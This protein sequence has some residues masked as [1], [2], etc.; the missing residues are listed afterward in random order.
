MALFLLF[1]AP[2]IHQLSPAWVAT[3]PAPPTWT[4]SWTFTTSTSWTPSPVPTS[5]TSWTSATSGAPT[6]TSPGPVPGA[7]ASSTRPAT[8]TR[9]ARSAS[10]ATSPPSPRSAWRTWTSSLG[11]GNFKRELFFWP[12]FFSK[13]RH[14]QNKL[15]QRKFAVGKWNYW[16]RKLLTNTLTQT[17]YIVFH[18]RR[19][20]TESIKTLIY[21]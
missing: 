14:D 10:P 4:T 1:Q 19:Q 15:N 2:P 11:C 13:S 5:A 9:T 21:L 7:S 6:G 12:D 3:T 16:T 18:I 8:P 20:M 17:S